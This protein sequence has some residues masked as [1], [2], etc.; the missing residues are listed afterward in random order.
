[1][2]HKNFINKIAITGVMGAGKSTVGLILQS[3]GMNV[4]SVD[5]LAHQ[6]IAPR[7]SGYL[8]L[9][10]LLG[11]EYLKKDGKFNTTKVAERIFQDKNMLQQVEAVIHPIV[12]KLL[13]KKE[14]HFI[15]L[16]QKAVFY[17]IPLLFEKKWESSFDV[18]IVIAIAPKEQQE[19]LKKNQK[20]DIKEIKNRMQF[21]MSQSDKIKR[22]DYVI[23]N[24]S[25]VRALKKQVFSLI[26]NLGLVQKKDSYL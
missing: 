15:F 26:Y 19:R 8:K 9:L 23:W 2:K 4:I 1:M 24:N 21:Q 12:W 11:K 25:S 20:W 7:S 16:R 14:E 13:K 22:A 10:Q 18:T 6:A 17:E 3:Y 5:V